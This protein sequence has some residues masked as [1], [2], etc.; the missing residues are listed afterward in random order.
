[1]SFSFNFAG[2]DISDT[3]IEDTTTNLART[4]ISSLSQS[5]ATPAPSLIPAQCHNLPSLLATLPSQLTY[6]YLTIPS[7]HSISTLQSKT[8]TKTTND[9]IHTRV[10]RRSLF[11]IRQQLMAESDPS[12]TTDS[13]NTLL[14][15]LE[16][17]D[18]S[19]GVYE[20]G[21]KTWECAV[22]LADYIS[23]H[24]DNLDALD[25]GTDIHV[26]ELG[27]GS[28]IP[29]LVLLRDVLQQRRTTVQSKDVQQSNGTT[30]QGQRGKV[31][32]TFCD[33]NA[34]VLRLCTAANVLLTTATLALGDEQTAA[35][36]NN[37]NEEDIDVDERVVAECL[38]RLGEA[39]VE[40][41]FISGAWGDEFTKLVRAGMAR[42]SG[43]A[44]ERVARKKILVLASET[45][46]AP[47]SL[48]VFARTVGDFLAMGDE[49]EEV[50]VSVYVAAK[51]VYFGVGGG[52][53]E[54]EEEIRKLGCRTEMVLDVKDAGVGRVVLEVKVGT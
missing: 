49:T 36:G 5:Q 21:F 50:D 1:M 34:D 38:R 48:G 37:E 47:E 23:S 13:T 51:K 43:A 41:D 18:L 20:G 27:A 8:G 42:A 14:E 2:D 16:S 30:R 25:E 45:I 7:H 11:D 53:A 28:A 22:D 10:P 29:S 15:G 44:E 31:K 19:N 40:V 3:E 33:Y 6:N 39:D 12:D 52:V 4:T 24:L 46:Y 54:F 35:A 26:I 17:G 32:F 9:S